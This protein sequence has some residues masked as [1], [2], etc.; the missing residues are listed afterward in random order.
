M[1]PS[2]EL[3]LTMLQ[4]SSFS[5]QY[6]PIKSK[7]FF[8]FEYDM[9]GRNIMAFVWGNSFLRQTVYRGVFK[10]LSANPTKWSNTHKQFVCKSRRIV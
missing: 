4:K 1:Q 9:K 8:L 5:K 6:L 10:P 2:I 7:N 3:Y